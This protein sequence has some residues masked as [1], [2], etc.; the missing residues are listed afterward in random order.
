MVAVTRFYIYLT[1]MCQARHNN[2]FYF[3]V[4]VNIYELYANEYFLIFLT[5][6]FYYM[7]FYINF[8]LP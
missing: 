7:K 3:T 4:I 5:E 6:I 1:D 8:D 2:N